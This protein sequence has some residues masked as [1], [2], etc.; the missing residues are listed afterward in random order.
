MLKRKVSQA[1]AHPAWDPISRKRYAMCRAM[2]ILMPE[3]CLPM[4]H[5]SYLVQLA[6]QLVTQ[7]TYL[8]CLCPE[9]H[10][11]KAKRGIERPKPLRH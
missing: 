7:S 5:V 2:A 3:Y 11:D 10:P 9:S 8:S 6:V 4:L 1:L